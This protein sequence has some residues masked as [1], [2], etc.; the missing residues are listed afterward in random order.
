MTLLTVLS[1]WPPFDTSVTA[2]APAG[3]SQFNSLWLALNDRPDPAQ[4][5]WEAL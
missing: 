4:A 1:L 3:P 5:E 2:A